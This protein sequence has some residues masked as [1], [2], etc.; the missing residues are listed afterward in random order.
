MLVQLGARNIVDAQPTLVDDV[1]NLFDS[2]ITWVVRFQCAPSNVP[3]IMDRE[4]NGVEYR[5]IL[6]VEGAIDEN[7]VVVSSLRSGPRTASQDASL[8][9]WLFWFASNF[10]CRLF[11]GMRRFARTVDQRFLCNRRRF[12]RANS[13]R[14]KQRLRVSLGFVDTHA[15]KVKIGKRISARSI[16]CSAVAGTNHT[17]DGGLT[18]VDQ[19]HHIFGI[20]NA[21]YDG[22]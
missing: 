8:R 14:H 12:Y 19:L 9:H 18:W 20:R 4:Y 2:D 15:V 21:G 3:T 22:S 13:N 5:L 16:A 11:D 6:R 10:L 17:I 1:E 7:A